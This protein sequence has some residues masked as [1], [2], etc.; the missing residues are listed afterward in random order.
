MAATACYVN[1]GAI[2]VI[3]SS[4]DSQSFS[5]I[6]AT[7]AAFQL[8]GGKYGVTCKASTYGTVT[9][10]VLA[11]DNTTYLTALAAF[12]ADGY[13]SVDLPNG[14]YKVAIA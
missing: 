3:G 5:N 10:Q 12:S 6:A 7:T 8:A 4:R 11:A 1:I 13:A 9:I 14:T 2:S